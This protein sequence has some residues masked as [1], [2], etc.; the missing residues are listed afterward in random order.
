MI[1]TE[2]LLLM[3]LKKEWY[4]A[5]I[6]ND[7]T[8]FERHGLKIDRAWFDKIAFNRINSMLS[9]LNIGYAEEQLLWLIVLEKTKV[10]IGDI[11]FIN[12]DK[13]RERSLSY[14]IIKAYRH[15]GYASEAIRALTFY[16]YV[17]GVGKVER[18]FAN[19]LKENTSSKQC[20]LS[21]NYRINS[22]VKE[23]SFEQFIFDRADFNA[24]IQKLSPK[25][26]VITSGCLLGLP[27]RYDGGSGQL[28]FPEQDTFHLIP[29]CPEQ[30]GGLG[31][32]REPVEY[33]QE[34][35]QYMTQ[36][37]KNC[38]E[39]FL[40]GAEVFVS[41]AKRY[42]TCLFFLKQNSPS[43]GSLAIYDGRFQG[44]KIEGEGCTVKLIQ[45]HFDHY[46]IMDEDKNMY[47]NL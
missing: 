36:T 37:G 19:V 8:V 26:Y 1:K 38:T 29:L 30:V 23:A 5:I 15:H 40:K 28:D 43:C 16:Y 32:P 4:E 12:S 18:L 35:N 39:A 7:V 24:L 21:A 47:I 17:L 20:I 31:T 10:I 14:R 42:Q 45:E 27:M 22:V 34:T 13:D 46:V 44:I 6:E 2:R 33:I 9:L 11:D 25:E 3:P 41:L